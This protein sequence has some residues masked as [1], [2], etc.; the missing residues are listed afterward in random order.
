MV[1]H[2]LIECYNE[3]HQLRIDYSKKFDDLSLMAYQT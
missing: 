1:F 3:H 2:L